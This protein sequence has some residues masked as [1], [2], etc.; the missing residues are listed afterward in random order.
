M[1]LPAG[2]GAATG[3]PA[4]APTLVVRVCIPDPP[5]AE[6]RAPADIC[7]V[8]DVSSSMGELATCNGGEE[9]MEGGLTMLDVVKHAVR[10]VMHTLQAGDRMSLVTFSDEAGLDE[11][12][13]PL[14]LSNLLCMENPYSYKKCQ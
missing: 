14:T 8:V 12:L 1:L 4:E 9:V 7:C 13:L 5:P 2:D 11:G 3:Y 6:P 10:T